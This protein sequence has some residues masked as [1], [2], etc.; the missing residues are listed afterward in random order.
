MLRIAA[1]SAAAAFLLALA[2]V[3]AS[4][5]PAETAFLQKLTNTW[6]G[7]GQLKGAESGAIACRIV[8]SSAKTSARYQGR[9]N[10]PDMAQQAFNGSI[11]YNDRAGR[12]ES[13]TAGGVVPGTRRGD[14]LVFTDSS[15]TV[16]GTAQSTMTISPSSLVVDFVMTDKAGKKTTSKITFS[17]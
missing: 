5:G 11:S 6:S 8:I 4:A 3:P 12:Y 7:R 1:L 2:A 13:R 9:C 17:R 10:I 14:R 15:R 16:Q